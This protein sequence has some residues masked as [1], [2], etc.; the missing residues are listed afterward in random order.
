V[1][2]QTVHRWLARYRD[3]T[4]GWLVDRS[5]RPEFCPIRPRSRSR[6]RCELRRERPRWGSRRLAHVLGQSGIVPVPSASTVYRILVRHG[7]VDAK[8]RRRRR[9]DYKRWERNGPMVL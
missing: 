6:R 9:D 2:R 4:L 1:S 5:H 8:A 7:L 3:E